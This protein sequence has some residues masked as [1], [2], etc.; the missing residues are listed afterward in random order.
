M[1]NED[2]NY[3]LKSN[4]VKSFKLETLVSDDFSSEASLNNWK[5]D[6]RNNN[7]QYQAKNNQTAIEDGV[8]KVTTSDESDGISFTNLVPSNYEELA[9]KNYGGTFEFDLELTNSCSDYTFTYGLIPDGN[10]KLLSSGHAD[11]LITVGANEDSLRTIDDSA[12]VDWNSHMM[13]TKPNTFKNVKR[14]IKLVQKGQNVV[15]YMDD[16]KILDFDTNM[17]TEGAMSFGFLNTNAVY[18]I[19]NVMW[20]RVNEL[21]NAVEVEGISQKSIVGNNASLKLVVNN[22]YSTAKPCKVVVA[23]Y[24]ST[25]KDMKSSWVS[26]SNELAPGITIIPVTDLDV[27]GADQIKVFLIDSFDTLVP[28]CVAYPSSLT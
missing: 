3:V 21:S 7:S 28:Y 4:W 23:A 15:M 5:W 2:E 1:T 22:S 18:K 17:T 19:D 9:A 24:S 10:T 26:E 27:T 8:L 20:T 11:A 13:F 16:Y 25:N 12:H 6:F 14:N